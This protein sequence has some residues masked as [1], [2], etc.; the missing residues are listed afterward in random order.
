MGGQGYDG[1]SG[2]GGPSIQEAVDA[3]R[4]WE[5]AGGHEV[6]LLSMGLGYTEAQ[7]HIDYFQSVLARVR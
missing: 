7:Q 5:D 2:Y 1:N 3:L 6:S 4:A